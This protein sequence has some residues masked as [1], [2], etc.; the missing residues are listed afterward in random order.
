MSGEN[1]AVFYKNVTAQTG[2][3]FWLPGLVLPPFKK[4]IKKYIFN[5]QNIMKINLNIV[6]D[7]IYKYAKFILK[8]FVLL[9]T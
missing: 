7:I 9:A 8:L 5:F 3:C 4:K 1:I 6:N 2:K